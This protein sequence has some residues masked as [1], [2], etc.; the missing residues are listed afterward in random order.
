MS[1]WAVSDLN[2]T[3]LKDFER[4]YESRTAAPSS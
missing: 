4:L 2:L 3:D 1:L